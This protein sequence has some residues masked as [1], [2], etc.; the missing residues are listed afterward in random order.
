MSEGRALLLETAERAFAELG[1]GAP[2]T[3]AWDQVSALGF[4]S[5]L[6]PEADG[7]FGG[8]WGDAFAVIRCAGSHALALPLGEVMVAAKL[9]AD[10][11]LS[12]PGSA[13]VAE[14]VRGEIDAAGRFS[15]RLA[16]PW[17]RHVR[18]VLFDVAG[19]LV[20]GSV[21]DAQVEQRVNPAGEPRDVLVFEAAPVVRAVSAVSALA[22]GAFVR[23]AQM[24]G[25]L[26]AALAMSIQ[27]AN[28]RQQFGKPIGKFQAVQQ[29]LAVF[30]EEAAAVNCA[31]QAA[32]RALERGDSGFEIAAAKVRANTAADLGAATAHQV[33]GAIGF[34]QEHAL[35]LLT[36]RLMS[37]RSEFGGDR[38]WSEYLGQRV[39]ARGADAFWSDLT[40]RDDAR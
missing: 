9:A 26:D 37:W 2:F 20:L 6:A 15:G 12:L 18:H 31:G 36:R 32:A 4:E 1:A 19:E 30:A 33:H 27:Y 34:T 21:S 39:C 8:D 14:T 5:L 17:G 25:A 16:S 10:S 22:A 7:G 35:H 28:E 23:V 24:A 38:R 3:T 13:V 11:G 29:A 40:A